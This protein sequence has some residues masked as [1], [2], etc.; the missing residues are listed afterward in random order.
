MI[1]GNFAGS[2]KYLLLRHS[3]GGHW[4]FPKGHLEGGETPRE[5]AIRELDEETGLSPEKILSGFREEV[6]YSY[7]RGGEEVDKTVIYFLA[8]VDSGTG[9]VTLSPEHLDYRWA[10]YTDALDTL[11]YNND[12]DVLKGAEASLTQGPRDD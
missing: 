1:A 6:S 4:S 9:E 5:A 10:T 8:L 7:R 2:R 11:T 3:N 12:I